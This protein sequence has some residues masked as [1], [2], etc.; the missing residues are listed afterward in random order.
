MLLKF[1]AFSEGMALIP[2]RAIRALCMDVHFPIK[3]LKLG[4]KTESD[5]WITLF[6]DIRGA[7]IYCDSDS[8]HAECLKFVLCS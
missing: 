2:S 1:S 3:G 5:W 8:V 4:G 7:G 6:K